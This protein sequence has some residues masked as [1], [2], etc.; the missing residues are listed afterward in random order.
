MNEDAKNQYDDA[1]NVLDALESMPWNAR[2]ILLVDLDAFFASVE[3]LDHPGWRGKPVI[4]GG[5]ADKRGVVST[6][7][8]EARKYGVHSAMA[9]STARRLCPDAIW[10]SGHFSRYREMSRAVMDILFDETPHVLQVSID[11]AFCDVTPTRANGEHPVTVARRIQRR[12]DELGVSCSIGVGTTK[13]VAKIA[14]DMDKPHGLTVV[15]PGSEEGFLTPLP[16]RLLSGIGSSAEEKLKHIGIETLGDL[17]H[18]DDDRIIRLLGKNGRTMLDRVR[19]LE[20]EDIVPDDEVKSVSNELSF[21]EDLVDRADIEAAIATMAAK[22]GRRLRRKDLKGKTLAL[23]VRYE[24]RSVHSVQRKLEKPC[25]DE[26]VFIGHLNEMLDAVWSEGMA[27]R[28][29]GVAVSDYDVDPGTEQLGLFD[30]FE[31]ATSDGIAAKNRNLVEATDRVRR[32]F[33]DGAISFGRELRT[34]ANTTGSSSKN[35]E[36]YK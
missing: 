27:L 21:A 16:L 4:V 36:D 20:D 6:A 31:Q 34:N 24:D 29:V 18:A 23:K 28:L 26:N 19:G 35:P 2:A 33:G 1:A 9:S 17:M 13:S 12:V 7:S 32:R 25:D 11:E 30:S 22:V 3:Q 15:F 14:S 8:Y 5:S 10:T